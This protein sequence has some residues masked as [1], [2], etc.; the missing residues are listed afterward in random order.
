MSA[1]IT[2][3]LLGFIG[4]GE[5]AF[6]ICSGLHEEGVTGIVAFDIMATDPKTGPLIRERATGAQVTLLTSLMEM[7]GKVEVILCATSAKAALAIAKEAQQFLRAGQLYADINSASPQVK[8]D[9]GAVIAP[10]G[11]LFVDTAV[12]AL[13]PQHRHK[14]PMAVSGTGA[15]RFA[16]LLAPCG[17]DITY[18]N[19]QAGSSSAI[20]MLRSIFIKGLAA[21]LLEAL[22]ASRKAGVERE[23]MESIRETVE[24]QPFEQLANLL[25]TRNA[26]SAERRVAEMGEVISCIEEMGLD[27]S[28]S[29]ATRAKLQAMVEMDLKTRFGH[30]PPVHY[31]QVLDAIIELSKKKEP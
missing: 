24:E 8:R 2:S 7:I 25:L 18:I 5:A 11:A 9:I 1:V 4:F 13:V 29:R 28:A 27:S 14:V 17:M 6:H 23:I 26:V 16:E 20:K 12:M 19:D 15:R 21:L 22:T 10:T 3:P 31:T 30:K